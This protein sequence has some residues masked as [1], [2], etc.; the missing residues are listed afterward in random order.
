MIKKILYILLFP[1]IGYSQTAFHNYGDVQIHTDGQIGFH[2]NLVNDGNFDDNVGFAGFYH[3]TETLTVSGDNRAVFY[4]S[5]ID[6]ANN[7]ELY[8]ALG[9]DNELSFVNGKVI[10]PRNDLNVSLDFINYNLYAGEDNNR[11]VDGYASILE[12]SDFTF[13]IGDDDRLR[14]MS[15]SDYDSN[16][17]FQGAYFYENPDFPSTFSTNFTTT[18]K[19]YLI[20]IVSNYEFWDLNADSQTTVTLTWDE[21]SNIELISPDLDSLIVVGW[22]IKNNRWENLGN[23]NISGNF[24]EGEI[25][26]AP[27]IPNEYEVI[28]FGSI[29]YKSNIF[30][31]SPNGD[32]YNQ[33]L[34]FDELLENPFS[35]LYIFN[36]WGNIVFHRKNYANDFDGTSDGRATVLKDKKLPVGTYFYELK[37]GRTENL[38]QEMRGWIYINR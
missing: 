32:E 31:I 26:S 34:V 17:L 29:T 9:I 14:I 20:D 37:Y 38:D 3:D 21:F 27:F 18:E 19:Y 4:N 22:S 25:S 30:L 15:I 33:T 36:R 28:T 11:H 2:T 12:N 7:L 13:P 16:N 8:T 35:E 5:E 6:V 24:S 10:T 1:L 23:T